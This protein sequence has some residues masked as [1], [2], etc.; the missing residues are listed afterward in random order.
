MNNYMHATD[1]T[2]RLG[3]ICVWLIAQSQGKT[4]D[5]V[6]KMKP[7]DVAKAS[8]PLIFDFPYP[9]FDTTYKSTLEEHFILYYYMYELGQETYNYWHLELMKEMQIKM[10][11]Y[12]KLYE[13]TLLKFDILDNINITETANRDVNG[14]QNATGSTNSKGVTGTSN[15]SV[16]SDT[17][18]GLLSGKNYATNA[19]KQDNSVTSTNDGSTKNESLSHTNETNTVNRKGNDGSTTYAQMIRQY[20]DTI[21]NVDLML[22]DDLRDLFMLIY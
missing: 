18:Q 14:S 16:Y 21:I 6:M 8:A 20:R 13:S 15:E 7:A 4:I 19:T 2:V 9:I 3:D 22:F 11:S 1:Y 5:D 12:N 17:P 10:P